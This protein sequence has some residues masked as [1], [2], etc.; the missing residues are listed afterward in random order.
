MQLPKLST[1]RS[2]TKEAYPSLSY[3]IALAGFKSPL[4]RV[5]ETYLVWFTSNVDFCDKP[6]G[7]LV[8]MKC[9]LSEVYPLRWKGTGLRI[10][11]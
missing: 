5:F 6:K 3:E 2:K 11:S 7:T 1:V 9:T 4:L 8:S 10:K